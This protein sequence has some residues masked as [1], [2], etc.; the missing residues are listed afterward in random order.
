[1]TVVRRSV[2]LPPALFPPLCAKTRSIKESLAA[3]KKT[4]RKAIIVIFSGTNFLLI[5][6]PWLRLC[7][8]AV[9]AA[10]LFKHSKAIV[11]PALFQIGVCA[12]GST[13]YAQFMF[14]CK[15]SMQENDSSAD[16]C[17]L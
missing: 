17:E 7:L 3:Q 6:P 1:M 5:T 16:H 8:L 14:I 9:L 2:L 10:C 13:R 4:A 15:S 12:D 11:E